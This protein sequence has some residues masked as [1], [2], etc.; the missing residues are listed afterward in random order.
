M[1]NVIEDTLYRVDREA[2]GAFDPRLPTPTGYTIL[3]QIPRKEEKQGSIYL[4]ESERKREEVASIK[5]RV[6]ALGCTAYQNPEKFPTGPWCKPGDWV[7]FAAYSGT[8]FFVAETEYRLM[9]DD[10]IQ[11]VTDHPDIVE[12]P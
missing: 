4:P 1:S 9:Y 5:G 2:S 8:R 6:V 12:R 7:M 10:N 3:V 11:A